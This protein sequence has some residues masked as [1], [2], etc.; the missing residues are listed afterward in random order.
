MSARIRRP[1]ST[2]SLCVLGGFA[3]YVFILSR[4]V[5]D[6]SPLVAQTPERTSYMRV[7]A[8]EL[9][10]AEDTFRLEPA[11][12]LPPNPVLACAIV[13]SE[14]LVFFRHGGFNW[15]QLLSQIFTRFTL[16][17]ASTI[18]QQLARNVFLGPEQ[19]LGRKLR[20]LFIAKELERT[21]SKRRILELY[22]NVIEWGD[23]TWGAGPAA[24]HYFGKSP[25][26][27]DAFEATFLS[28]LTAAPRHPLTGSNLERAEGVQHRVL[29]QLYRS[30][31]LDEETWREAD[32]R[33]SA[34]FACLRQGQPLNAAFT[35][36]EAPPP[37]GTPKPFYA[38][39]QVE[40]LRDWL[41]QGCG[42]ERESTEVKAIRELRR[43]EREQG[44][45][46]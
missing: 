45:Q 22:L 9:N 39:T 14:D 34:V 1:F 12:V 21:L 30:G 32:T 11:E 36:T 3:V 43:K 38:R 18:T 19:S 15:G 2:A 35:C 33:A 31:I 42:L 46:P 6:V 27:L 5:P 40:P 7:R 24:K 37:T 44:K 23:G 17:G 25:A 29:L 10:K 16:S 13:K 8:G 26:E 28:A 20:E 4:T 41:E